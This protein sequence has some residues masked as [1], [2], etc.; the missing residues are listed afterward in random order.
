MIPV[1]NDG[2]YARR[3][4]GDAAVLCWFDDSFRIARVHALFSS[5]QGPDPPEKDL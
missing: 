5:V 3:L 4:S 2:D 1:R